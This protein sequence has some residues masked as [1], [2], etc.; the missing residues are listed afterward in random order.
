[1]PTMRAPGCVAKIT[2]APSVVL[3]V[4]DGYV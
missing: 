1:M 3:G 4:C 2:I